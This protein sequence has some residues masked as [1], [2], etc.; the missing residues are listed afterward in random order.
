MSDG[1]IAAPAASID[2]IKVTAPQDRPLVLY[3]YTESPFARE[4]LEFFLDHGLHAAADFVFILNGETDADELI[5]PD[6]KYFQKTKRQDNLNGIQSSPEADKLFQEA[7]KKLLEEQKK[8]EE[9]LREAKLAGNAG[10]SNDAEQAKLQ[11]EVDAKVE[12]LKKIKAEEASNTAKEKAAQ[13]AAEA[14]EKAQQAPSKDAGIDAMKE[15]ALSQSNEFAQK[16]VD[17]HNRIW[18]EGAA[19]REHEKLVHHLPRRPRDNVKIVRRPNKCYDLGAHAEILNQHDNGLGLNGEGWYDSNGQLPATGTPHKEPTTEEKAMNGTG[20]GYEHLALRW[21]YK[22]YI[23]MNASIRGPF[24]PTWSQQCWS[25]AY[26]NKVTPVVK[27]VGLSYNC[28]RGNGHVQSMIWATDSTGL[29]ELLRPDVL[30]NCPPDMLQAIQHEV[31][32]TTHLRQAGYA[33]DTMLSIYQ[34]RNK[35]AKLAKI[36]EAKASLP[37]ELDANNMHMTVTLDQPGNWWED[38]CG[39]H[40]DFLKPVQAEDSIYG[41][42]GTFVHPFETIFMKSH[43]AIE[44]ITMDRLTEWIDGEGYESYDYCN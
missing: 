28:N 44:D 43:R 24:M 16:K 22:R 25:D 39:A 8:T 37:A 21:R 17:E 33:V 40:D 27:L 29:Q 11:A 42:Y 13:D 35:L 12:E 38:G 34:S 15:A 14:D 4:N 7:K 36:A 41:Y 9:A 2:S 31:S 6:S 20:P 23:L 3:A 32:A 30:G 5:F 19:D 1:E 26:L 10:A 18:K